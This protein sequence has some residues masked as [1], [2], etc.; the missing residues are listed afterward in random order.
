MCASVV[1]GESERG[2]NDVNISTSDI[3]TFKSIYTNTDMLS[4]KLNE[5]QLF[6]EKEDIDLVFITETLSKFPYQNGDDKDITFTLQGYDYYYCN[7]G[8]GVAVFIKKCYDVVEIKD[9]DVGCHPS[10]LSCRTK[11]RVSSEF[12]YKILL[13]RFFCPYL[14]PQR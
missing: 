5:L 14:F 1:S 3:Q 9:I 13:R 6:V 8:R 2:V 12:S 7:K 10:D 4:N 11:Q